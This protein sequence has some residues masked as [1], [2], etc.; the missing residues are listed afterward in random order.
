[1]RA[2]AQRHDR[3][4]QHQDRCPTS[5]R[6]GHDTTILH[7]PDHTPST[8]FN[9]AIGCFR[10]SINADRAVVIEDER[11]VIF[12]PA[13]FAIPQNALKMPAG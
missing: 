9:G 4:C 11:L 8:T 3:R 7:Q 5:H 1:L 12:A 13:R 10:R 2:G 6:F